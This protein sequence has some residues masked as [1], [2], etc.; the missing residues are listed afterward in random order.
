MF[1]FK[2]F[3]LAISESTQLEDPRQ[4]WR[5]I[6]E[7]M[8]REYLQTAQDE[9]EVSTLIISQLLSISRALIGRH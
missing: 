9:L 7:D 4:E 6:Q 5:I 3:S 8:L 1:V 2:S